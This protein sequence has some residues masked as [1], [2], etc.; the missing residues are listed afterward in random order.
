MKRFFSLCL[1]VV[2]LVPGVVLGAAKE[3]KPRSFIKVDSVSAT[4]NTIT[5]TET[6]QSKKTY[7]VDSFTAITVNGKPGKL[8]DIS[9]GMKVECTVS[10]KKAS[11]LEVSDAPEEK[12]DKKK[13]K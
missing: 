13:K 6:D 7:T 12:P 8:S 1:L 10:G 4:D 11:R 3:K 5:I 9:S 2:V